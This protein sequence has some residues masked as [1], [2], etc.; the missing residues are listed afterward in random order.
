M[1]RRF[2]RALAAAAAAAA[3]ALAGVAAEARPLTP[4]EQRY[5]AYSGAV[6]ACDD[7]AVLARI[8]SRFRQKESEYWQSSAEIVSFDKVREAGFRSWGA[9]HIPRR[10]C[11]A[12]ANLNASPKPHGVVYTVGEGLGTIGWGFGVEWCVQ[13]Y[14]RNL[15]FAPGC[16]AAGP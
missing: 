13:G 10:H 9:D 7:P 15:A 8:Q 16:R 4:A 12:L 5:Q 3:L 6:P 14:D 2:L 1:D 11:E